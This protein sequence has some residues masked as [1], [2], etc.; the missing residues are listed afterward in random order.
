MVEFLDIMMK[1][2]GST[3]FDIN[4]TLVDPYNY[5]YLVVMVIGVIVRI[6]RLRSESLICLSRV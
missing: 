5:R 3:V 2:P 1:M 6:G 4:V